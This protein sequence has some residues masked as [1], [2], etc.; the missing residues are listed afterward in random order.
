[1]HRRGEGVVSAKR[2]GKDRRRIFYV[3]F[4]DLTREA[5]WTVHIREVVDN[6]ERLGVSVTL[7][8]PRIWPFSASPAG[9]VVYVPTIDVRILREYLYLLLVPFYVLLFGRRGRPDA[10]YCREMSLLAPIACAA[11]LLRAPVVMEINGFILTDLRRIGTSRIKIAVLRL[12]QWL[13]LKIADAL[14]FVGLHH[15]T[16]FRHEYAIDDRK[17]HLVSNGVDTEAFSPG[18]PAEA[19]RRLGLDKDKKYVTFVGTFH[20]HSMT[21]TIVRAAAVVA[22]VRADVDFIMIGDGHDLAYCKEL[23]AESAAAGRIVFPGTVKNRDIPP[24]LRASTVLIDL[25]EGAED[26]ASMKILEYLSSGGVVIVNTATVFGIPL[27]HGRDCWRID[28]TSPGEL[29]RAVV[30]LLDD[31]RLCREI[32]KNARNLVLSHFSWR[33]T[34]EK[35]LAVIDEVRDGR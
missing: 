13:N 1:M 6:W 17:V 14:I 11:R 28:D 26:S 30:T 7:F 3:C 29:A 20:P 35:L 5:A 8:A 19:I 2:E 10:V 21:P 31:D 34:A 22:A 27:V 33:S 25:I 16:Q 23:A 4:E 12:F 24:Y 32:G 15:L 9:E 18:S